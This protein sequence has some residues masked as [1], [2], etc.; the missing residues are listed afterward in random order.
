MDESPK[1]PDPNFAPLLA[2]GNALAS[3]WRPAAGLTVNQATLR[4]VR[5]EGHFSEFHTHEIDEC[6]VVLD[7]DLVIEIRDEGARLLRSGD[8]YVVRAGTVHRP[9]AMPRATVLLVT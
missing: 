8:A 7:G 3:A 9:Y 6:Y 2:I 1:K 4:V 5:F